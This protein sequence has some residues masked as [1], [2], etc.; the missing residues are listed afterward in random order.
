LS[1]SVTL[2]LVGIFIYYLVHSVSGVQTS[3]ANFLSRII[4]MYMFV[5]FCLGIYVEAISDFVGFMILQK[6]FKDILKLGTRIEE[7]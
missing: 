3:V 7:S 4:D 1:D 6:R 5:L 2:V